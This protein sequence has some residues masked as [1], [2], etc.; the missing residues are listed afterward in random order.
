MGEEVLVPVKQENKE[1]VDYNPYLDNGWFPYHYVNKFKSIR[2]AMKRGHIL[3]MQLAPK[4][5][6][7]NRGNTSKRR[8]KHSRSINE[9]KKRIYGNITSKG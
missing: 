8:F 4:R 1:Q 7:N 2:R 9:C 5:P 3:A 6:F